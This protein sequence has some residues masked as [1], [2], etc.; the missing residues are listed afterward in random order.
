MVAFHSNDL[1]LSKNLYVFMKNI[2][3]ILLALL[4][5]SVA[6][7]LYQDFTRDKK[8]ESMGM[9]TSG[10][11]LNS[12]MVYVNIDTLLENYTVYQQ[13]KAK[14]E[15]DQQAAE[16]EIAKRSS[17]L[18]SEYRDAQKNAQAGMLTELQ[19]AQLEEKLMGKQQA[20]MS[21]KQNSEDKLVE[22]NQEMTKEIFANIH[23][24]LKRLNE[25]ANYQFVFGYT[26]EGGI[27]LANDSLNIT[28]FVVDGLNKEALK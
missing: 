25:K 16:S 8:G 10:L 3:S 19:M 12:N 28:P 4:S 18:E 21:F 26:K 24:F 17:N 20:L 14:F 5:I 22:A 9:P 6:F 23:G 11:S 7:L 2:P 1:L 15:A 27:L 13:K